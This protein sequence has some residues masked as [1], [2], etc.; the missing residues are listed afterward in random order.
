MLALLSYI[1]APVLWNARPSIRARPLS[2][3]ASASE[4]LRLFAGNGAVV[5]SQGIPLAIASV[6][7]MLLC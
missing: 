5:L 1:Q 2:S 6:A 4:S 7:A 3:R